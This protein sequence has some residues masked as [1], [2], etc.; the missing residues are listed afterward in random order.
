MDVFFTTSTAD[1]NASA[2]SVCMR[3]FEILVERVKGH[4]AECNSKE[5]QFY[6]SCAEVIAVLHVESRGLALP[7]T[8]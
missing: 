4:V 7:R 5:V 2:L 6:C 1:G 8:T 3:L